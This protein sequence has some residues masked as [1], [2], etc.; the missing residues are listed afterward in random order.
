[1]SINNILFERND[2]VSRREERI[3][4][5]SK[6]FSLRVKYLS[7]YPRVI[8]DDIDRSQADDVIRCTYRTC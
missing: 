4:G 8:E 1:M 2:I 6:T 7:L 5:K 3:K